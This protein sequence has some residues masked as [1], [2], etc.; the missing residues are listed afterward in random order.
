MNEWTHIPESIAKQ[1][2]DSNT[3]YTK[4]AEAGEEALKLV[5]KVFTE[6]KYKEVCETTLKDF[7]QATHILEIKCSNSKCNVANYHTH[8]SYWLFSFRMRPNS[9]CRVCGSP[10]VCNIIEDPM[11][12]S[13]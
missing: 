13:I 11:K 3:D 8:M 12:K 1:P 5:R 4:L 2:L 7:N 10:M 6:I 9:G